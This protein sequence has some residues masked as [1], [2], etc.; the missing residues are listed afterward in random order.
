MDE[1]LKS[2]IIEAMESL[3]SRIGQTLVISDWLSTSGRNYDRHQTRYG[4][5]TITLDE[6]Y[7]RT[8]GAIA[9]MEG[10]NQQLEFRS[11]CIKFVTMSKNELLIEMDLQNNTWRRL[12]ICNQT[13][14][15]KK[16]DAFSFH[17]LFVVKGSSLTKDSQSLSIDF[18][19]FNKKTNRNDRYSLDFTGIVSLELTDPFPD[20]LSTMEIFSF[21]YSCPELFEGNVSFVSC[22]GGASYSIEFKCKDIDLRVIL[23]QD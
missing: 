15:L 6:F 12:K 14:K 20:S 10:R 19:S 18:T 8:S 13:E 21:R 22:T 2:K 4:I 23:Q 5:Q 16:L 7:I 11:D 1:T 3:Y 9:T 17:D